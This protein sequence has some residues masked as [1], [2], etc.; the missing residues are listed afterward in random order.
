MSYYLCLIGGLSI[1]IPGQLKG[2]WEIYKKFGGGVRWSELFNETISLCQKGFPVT[3]H[4]AECAR[5]DA[6]NYDKYTLLK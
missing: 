1:A 5:N 2:L 6:R 3:K 4:L